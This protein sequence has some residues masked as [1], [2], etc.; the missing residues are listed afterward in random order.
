MRKP[1]GNEAKKLEKEFD[2]M[3]LLDLENVDHKKVLRLLEI[4]NLRQI[5]K[6]QIVFRLYLIFRWELSKEEESLVAER[7]IDTYDFDNQKQFDYKV[8]YRL[9][10]IGNKEQKIKGEKFVRNCTNPNK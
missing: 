9:M 5:K 8:G 1:N 4:G 7:F 2:N 10:F 6:A 3:K